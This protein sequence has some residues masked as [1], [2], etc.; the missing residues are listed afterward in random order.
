[1]LPLFAHQITDIRAYETKINDAYPID[2]ETRLKDI[3][4]DTFVWANYCTS[5]VYD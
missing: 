2:S 1:M 5:N 4:E 3:A